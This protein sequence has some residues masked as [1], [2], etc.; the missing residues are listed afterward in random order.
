[1]WATFGIAD[2]S[3]EP[4]EVY[5]QTRRFLPGAQ[6]KFGQFLSGVGYLNRQHRHQWDFVD[7]PLPYTALFGSNLEDVG[8]QL[9]W[10]PPIRVYTQFGFE[11]LQGDN[12]LI[13]NQLADEYSLVLEERPGPRLFT[14]FLK[15][16]PNLGYSHALQTGIALGRSRSHQEADEGGN[17]HDGTA[18]FFLTDW[19]WRYDSA[20][21]YGER[22]VTVQGEYIYRSKTLE[23]VSLPILADLQETT[24][25]QDGLYAQVVYGV[26]PRWTVAGRF[27]A[28][29]L[30]NHVAAL[31]GMTDEGATTR[32]STNV[33]FNP[34]EFSR[35]RVQYDY[36][37]VPGDSLTRFHQV[38]VQFQ[39]SLGVH[40]AHTF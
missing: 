18:W 20:R 31:T 2:G 27:D 10:L 12:G 33:T 32:Y 6:V 28:A 13:A 29:G 17:V 7:A 37:R 34:T 9:T 19:V 36:T 4:E 15:V 5:V 40:G 35:L 11:A 23:L 24:S 39:M 30:R 21:P 26:G 16:S 3:I 14:G 8:V 38:Y 22:D 25:Q 1:V